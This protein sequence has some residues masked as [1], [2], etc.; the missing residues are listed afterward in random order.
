MSL[1]STVKLTIS[2]SIVAIFLMIYSNYQNY[3][4]IIKYQ[5]AKD[6]YFANKNYLADINK[7]T[8]DF[9]ER[10]KLWKLK[11]DK[12]SDFDFNEKSKRIHITDVVGDDD[13]VKVYNDKFN[14]ESLKGMRALTE[15]AEFHSLLVRWDSRNSVC[16]FEVFITRDILINTG[17]T[18]SLAS[19]PF[20][21]NQLNNSVSDPYRHPKNE[22]RVFTQQIKDNWFYSFHYTP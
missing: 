16:H 19:H 5:E 10:N 7:T 8:C 3:S 14:I 11:F 1:S 9:M 20:R 21:L 6:I 15:K 4:R 13:Y 22:Q 12:D 18:V 2:L 17:T